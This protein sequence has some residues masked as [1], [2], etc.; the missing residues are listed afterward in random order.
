MG[1]NITQEF[2]NL[3][4]YITTGVLFNVILPSATVPVVVILLLGVVLFVIIGV[5]FKRRYKAR[6]KERQHLTAQL[7]NLK[8]APPTAASTMSKQNKL[9]V[10]AAPF[11]RV[12]R[13]KYDNRYFIVQHSSHFV[14]SVGVIL[15]ECFCTVPTLRLAS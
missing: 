10:G 5:L 9:L 1:T 11:Q 8:L 7:R 15:G 14:Y 4:L 2:D 3:L 12:G 6:V 13:N